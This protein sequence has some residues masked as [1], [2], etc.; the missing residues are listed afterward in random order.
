VSAGAFAD[1]TL[2]SVRLVHHHCSC[3]HQRGSSNENR[4]GSFRHGC[5]ARV[6]VGGI[7]RRAT[8]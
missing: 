8:L 6:A 5:P 3:S 2:V 4:H 7:G 1:P